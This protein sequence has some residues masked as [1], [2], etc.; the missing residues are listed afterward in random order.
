M[1][2]GMLVFLFHI[3]EIDDMSARLCF[4]DEAICHGS[5]RVFISLSFIMLI[6]L[7][8]MSD[9]SSMADRRWLRYGDIMRQM[10]PK[11]LAPSARQ[12]A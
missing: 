2:I 5:L 11:W 8:E 7:Y 12:R 10:R 6:V 9:Q 3:G 4:K 1:T